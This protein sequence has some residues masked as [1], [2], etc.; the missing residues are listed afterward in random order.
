MLRGA[1]RLGI[2][3]WASIEPVIIPSESLEI[4]D[5]AIP[6]TDEFKIGKWN[7]DKEADKI[8]WHKF[9]ADAEALMRKYHKKYVLKEDLLKATN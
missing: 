5:R 9:R 6:F 4:M 2:T 8:N 1:H 3:T 7:H